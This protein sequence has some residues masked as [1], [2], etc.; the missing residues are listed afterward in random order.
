MCIPY[1]IHIITYFETW[2]INKSHKHIDLLAS[3]FSNILCFINTMF[4]K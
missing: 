3:G 4:K 2:M 1:N